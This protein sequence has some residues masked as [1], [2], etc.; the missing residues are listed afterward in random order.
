MPSRA[1]IVVAGG[2]STRFGSDKLTATLGN[3]TLVEATVAAMTPYVDQVVVATRPDLHEIVAAVA[4]NVSAV[5]GGS[6]R[7]QSE[8]AGLSALGTYL[9]L[10]GIHDAARPMV[11]S[12]LLEDLFTAAERSGGAIPVISP[13]TSIIDRHTLVVR[14]GLVRAQTPQVFDAQ[15]LARAYDRAAGA[16]Y[17][18]KDTAD[19]VLR[20]GDS[21]EI[22]AVPG[23][24]K[25]L[26]VTYPRD[27]D[28]INQ[29]LADPS[30][31][32]TP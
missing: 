8:I 17:E 24:R 20:F 19:V 25:N 31:S 13:E 23:D 4:P 16:S 12:R 7:T 11:S 2:T 26:K 1:M 10:V 22:E 5:E 9:G 30:H 21:V 32:D 18:G 28:A 14:D 27:L 15:I 29:L 3:T 6:T